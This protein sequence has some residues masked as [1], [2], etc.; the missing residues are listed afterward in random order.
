M[1][2]KKEKNVNHL[3]PPSETSANAISS[4]AGSESLEFCELT[5]SR[6]Q[7]KIAITTRH[8]V[9]LS[10]FTFHLGAKIGA[11]SSVEITVALWGKP[12]NCIFIIIAISFTGGGINTLSVRIYQNTDMLKTSTAVNEF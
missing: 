2:R 11:T 12:C 10:R 5:R 9:H 4:N 6:S 8:F 7:P 1:Y 3:S